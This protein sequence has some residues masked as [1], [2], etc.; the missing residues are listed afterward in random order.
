[1]PADPSFF[2]NKP[3]LIL[4]S[5]NCSMHAFEMWAFLLSVP[6]V[7]EW[8]PDLTGEDQGL[9]HHPLES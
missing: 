9:R 2:S 7:A 6:R 5:E 1:M 3:V 4:S 8:G